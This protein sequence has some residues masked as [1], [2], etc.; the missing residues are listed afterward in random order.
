MRKN[1]PVSTYQYPLHEKTKLMSVTTPDSHITYANKD[2]IQVSGYHLEELMNQPHNIIRHPDMPPSAFSDM[3]KTLQAG[4]IWTGIVKNRR[5]NGD[6]YWVKSS[7]TPLKKEGQLTGYMSVR[8]PATPDEIQQAKALYAAVNE[9]KLK[10]RA[11]HHGLLVYTGPLRL[12]SIFKTMPLRWRI[13]SYC[14][15]FGLIPLIAAYSI[16]ATAP[17]A[18]LLF[19][20]LI[21]CGFISCELLVRHVAHPIEQILSQAMRSAAGQA[22][23]LTQLNRVDEIGMLMRAVNQSGMNFRTFVDDVSSNL[24]E[25]KTA[26]NEIAQG[27]QILA[28]CCEQTEE[29]LQ[30]TAASVE[31]LTATIK[32]NADASVQAS[33]YTRDVNQAVNSGEQ[34]VNQVSST[35]ETITRSSERI[36]D[37]INV[38]DNLAFQTNILAVNAAV[39]AA[40][41]GEQGKSFAVVASEVR[42]LAQRSASS[43]S[44]ISSIIDETLSSIRV[45]EEL[46]SHTHKSMSNILLQVQNVTHLMN[47]ISLATQEQSQGVE[48]INDAVNKIDELTHQN[49]ALASQSNSATG[50]LQQQI[51][52]MAQAVSVFS[53]SR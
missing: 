35:M 48:L 45:G 39:E 22:D 32:S 46:V 53:I 14:L 37:I 9:G 42:S 33:K 3:W 4:H 26:C 17:L 49:T 27:N 2:F 1:L 41:A 13:R 21:A 8:T 51:S 34:A 31:Q 7:T 28:N 10:H 15:L 52:S 11:F 47:E 18:A 25:L 24:L 5:K 43:S 40:H 50:H 20:L 38:L 29:N 19:P 6:H 23:N 30:Q 12:L 16:M 36:T 44:D